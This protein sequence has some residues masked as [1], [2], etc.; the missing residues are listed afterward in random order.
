RIRT[1]WA[2]RLTPV[3]AISLAPAAIRAGEVPRPGDRVEAAEAKMEPAQN[4]RPADTRAHYR[5]YPGTAVPVEQGVWSDDGGQLIESGASE[6]S[7]AD[8]EPAALGVGE[9]RPSSTKRL[10]E[11]AIFF[12]RVVDD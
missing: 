10:F 3:G 6:L 12:K 1:G 7:S 8:G 11:N 4:Q 2:V 9:D 5:H